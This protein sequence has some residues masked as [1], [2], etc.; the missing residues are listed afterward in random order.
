[1]AIRST[2]KA[3]V[4]CQDFTAVGHFPISPFTAVIG[5]HAVLGLPCIWQTEHLYDMAPNIFPAVVTRGSGAG[6]LEVSATTRKF[7]P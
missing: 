3:W 2:P 7:G 5:K 4:L 1:M 6:G